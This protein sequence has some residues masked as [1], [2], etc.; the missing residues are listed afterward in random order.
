MAA[1]LVEFSKALSDLVTSSAPSIVRVEARR[2]LPASGIVWST[3]GLIVSANHVVESDEDISIGLHDG[4]RVSASVV[5]RD[6]ATDLI[7]LRT[8][9]GEFATPVWS[10]QEELSA[11]SLAIAMGRPFHAVEVSVGTLSAVGGAWRTHG[12]GRIDRYMRSEV[13][14]FPG[15]SGG[16]L[17]L[18]SG[19][20]AGLN[21]SGLAHHSDTTLPA[22]TVKRTVETIVTHGR[23]PRGYLGIG[24]QPVRISTAQADRA[25]TDVGLMVMSVEEGS[26]AAGAGIRQGDI[27]FALGDQVINSVA[28]L[29]M[30]LSA[31]DSSGQVTVRLVRGEDVIDLPADIELR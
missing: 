18:A 12:G 29:R 16:P 19:H 9:S 11:G 2:R 8:E 21:T 22:E 30:A 15:F 7:V 28:D 17:V 23:I 1:S 14:M 20:F 24:V 27:L 26:P 31:V 6:P 5:G 3:D 13:T 25:D 4:S 10:D